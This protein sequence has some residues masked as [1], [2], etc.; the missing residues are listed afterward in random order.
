ETA[1]SAGGAQALTA[2]GA[3]LL[4]LFFSWLPLYIVDVFQ[5][6]GLNAGGRLA[7]MGLAI[8][9]VVLIPAVGMGM[10]FPLLTDIVAP[11]GESRGADVGRAYALNTLGSIV[12]AALTGFVLVVW[13]GTD[14]TLR[15]G[16]VI[17]AAAATS[18][19]RAASP[20]GPT[21]PRPRRCAPRAACAARPCLGSC[22]AS[23]GGAP[24]RGVWPAAATRRRGPGSARPPPRVSSSK[25][26]V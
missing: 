15:L 12:G 10:T 19:A 3:A 18:R 16:V 5:I 24:P 6:A 4:F 13:L 2:G 8:G 9:A 26:H 14:V 25:A 22:C 20:A 1:A 7:L 17:D 21:R 11:E 23:G